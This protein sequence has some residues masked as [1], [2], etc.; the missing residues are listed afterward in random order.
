VRP[1]ESDNAL[2]NDLIRVNDE[3]RAYIHELEGKLG[4]PPSGTERNELP[5][6]S[7]S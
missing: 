5:A 3:F 6:G 7:E 1:R 4:L 2:V